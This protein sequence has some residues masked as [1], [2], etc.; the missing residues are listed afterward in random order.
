[1]YISW[2]YAISNIPTLPREVTQV[3]KN[4]KEVLSA[5]CEFAAGLSNAGYG[6]KYPKTNQY[7]DMGGVTHADPPEDSS[8]VAPSAEDGEGPVAP[9]AQMT[10]GPV[11]PAAEQ[12]KTISEEV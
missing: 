5:F 2:N 9:P 1:M 8:V 6:M 3:A 4:G 10:E 12:H 7:P 11:A